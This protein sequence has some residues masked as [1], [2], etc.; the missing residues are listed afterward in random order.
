MKFSHILTAFLATLAIASPIPEPESTDVAVAELDVRASGGGK[1]GGHSGGHG[2]NGGK[3]D[4]E[5]KIVE[6]TAYQV[7]KKAM[8]FYE[9]LSK[10]HYYYFTMEWKRGRPADAETTEELEEV[11]DELGFNHIGLVVGKVTETTTG[12]KANK[13]TKKDFVA[14]VHDMQKQNKDPGTTTYLF[15]KYMPKSTSSSSTKLVHGGKTT[16]SKANAVGKHAR[17]YTSAN[18]IYAAH[19]NNCNDFVQNLIS[20]L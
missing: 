14:M 7:A 2:G 12:K 19:G 18:P 13:V 20:T 10:D 9:S 16:L 17:A 1:G 5:P 11:R 8:P 6:T 4:P 15:S 3:G